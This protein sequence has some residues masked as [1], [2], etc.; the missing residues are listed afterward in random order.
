VQR[1]EFPKCPRGCDRALG[2]ADA[3]MTKTR[4]V[5]QQ[6]HG[7]LVTEDALA[8]LVA[9]MKPAADGDVKALPFAPLAIATDDPPIT[10]PRCATTMERLALVGIAVDRCVAHG[11]WFD[12][13]ELGLVLEIA[14]PVPES[15]SWI[16][17]LAKTLRLADPGP[18]GW[19]R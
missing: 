19:K 7:T 5:C 4:L 10:C 6:C 3:V 11:V 8:E 16:K 15:E 14:A 1:D 18:G 2:P 13:A 9:S 12:G 17:T